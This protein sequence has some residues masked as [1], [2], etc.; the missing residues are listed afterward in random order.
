MLVVGLILALIGIDPI[1]LIF[2]AN[3]LAGLMAPLL[4]IAI[5]FVGNNRAIMKGQRLSLLNTISLVLIAVI[6][7]SAVGLLFYGLLTGQGGS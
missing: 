7:V 6:L 2:W 1:R 5:L 3:V 4:V